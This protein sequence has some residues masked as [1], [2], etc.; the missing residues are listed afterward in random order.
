MMEMLHTPEGRLVVANDLMTAKAQE[1]AIEIAKG[2]APPLEAE[3]EEGIGAEAAAETA[4][5]EAVAEAEAE[6]KEEPE[7]GDVTECEAAIEG[8]AESAE[9]DNSEPDTD[10]P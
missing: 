3:E 2:E 1:R 7:A 9:S 10:N 8:E 4:K 6:I 5:E